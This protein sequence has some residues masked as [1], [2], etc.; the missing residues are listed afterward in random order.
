MAY[1]FGE[2]MVEAQYTDT[3]NALYNGN[4]L[5]EALPRNLNDEELFKAL[6]LPIPYDQTERNLPYYERIER[7][8]GLEYLFV[9]LNYVADITRKIFTAIKGGYVSRNPLSAS[10]G[11]DMTK[12]QKCVSNKDGAFLSYGISNANSSGFCIVGDSGMGKTSSINRALSL[13]PQVI[14]HKE[15][16][17]NA[18]SFTQIVWL[19]LECPH[20]ASVKGMCSEFFRIF[21]ELTGDN[22]FN[23][24]A[25]GGR[26]T[27]DQ[28]VPQMAMVAKRHGLGLLIIDEIQNLSAAKSG[29]AE[30][31][32][33]FIVQLV[34][35]VGIPVL[36]VGTPP[37]IELL[38]DDL[39][40]IRRSAGDGMVIIR[41]LD[42]TSADWRS[43]VRE[44]WNYQWT[45]VNTKGSKNLSDKLHELCHG[46]IDAAI[47][48]YMETQRI[49]INKGRDPAWPEV[50]TSDSIQSAA[51]SDSL[52][53]VLER[54]AFEQGGNIRRKKKPDVIPVQPKQA[55]PKPSAPAENKTSTSIEKKQKQKLSIG[56]ELLKELKDEGVLVSPE[57]EY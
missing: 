4:P 6:Y 13:L 24:F 45:S 35:T 11:H 18:F 20:D 3:G 5:I 32:K 15:Y 42:R 25:V 47:K 41:P 38:K 9:P 27:V 19:K 49:T 10:W 14:I 54:L 55:L 52:R 7:L 30:R 57:D 29:G 40:T 22:T 16:R 44:I 43:F 50:I 36:L 33:N 21:D 48:L 56:S 23:K 12:L 2:I 39:K 31:M 34:N 37:T 51:E 46:N 8:Q 1:Q 26:A 28:M 17:E 53:L